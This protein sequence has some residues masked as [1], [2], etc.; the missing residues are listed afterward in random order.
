MESAGGGGPWEADGVAGGEGAARAGLG[1]R[2]AGRQQ[3]GCSRRLESRGRSAEDTAAWQERRW[4][5]GL[6][7]AVPPT[8]GAMS[9]PVTVEHVTLWGNAAGMSNNRVSSAMVAAWQWI[10]SSLA[11][12]QQLSSTCCKCPDCWGPAGLMRQ[13]SCAPVLWAGS[14]HQLR[15]SSHAGPGNA[16]QQRSNGSSSSG[17]G[18]AAEDRGGGPPSSAALTAP[19]PPRPCAPPLLSILQAPP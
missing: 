10:V 2:A 5:G 18:R 12:R 9:Q 19:A 6:Q 16:R 13:S 7:P 11:L 17:E 15:I 1:W 14:H 4:L 8:P 3:A